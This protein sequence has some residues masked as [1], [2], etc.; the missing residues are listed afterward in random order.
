MRANLS[1]QSGISKAGMLSRLKD[2]TKREDLLKN[3]TQTV[4]VLEEKV[5]QLPA[6]GTSDSLVTQ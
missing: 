5:Q 6:R 3:L 4:S 2:R 1:G